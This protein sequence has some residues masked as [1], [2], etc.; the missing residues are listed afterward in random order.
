M[1][2]WMVAFCT[3]GVCQGCGGCARGTPAGGGL[4]FCLEANVELFVLHVSRSFVDHAD[5][6]QR[7]LGF[8]GSGC[9]GGD[10]VLLFWVAFSQSSLSTVM[11]GSIGGARILVVLFFDGVSVGDRGQFHPKTHC[12]GHKD[13]W[14]AVEYAR[15]HTVTSSHRENHRDSVKRTSSH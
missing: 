1:C 8:Q 7:R 3:Q 10:K 12:G 13:M 5:R 11:C 6:V 14:G 9:N 15:L 4:A 2:T